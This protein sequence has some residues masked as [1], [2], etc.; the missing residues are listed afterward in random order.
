MI[1]PSRLR[2]PVDSL[3]VS[4]C[5][6]QSRCSPDVQDGGAGDGGGAICLVL[7]RGKV[8]AAVRKDQQ[9]K[10]SLQPKSTTNAAAT[11]SATEGGSPGGLDKVN[12]GGPGEPESQ[13]FLSGK[14]EGSVMLGGERRKENQETKDD[15]S[16]A[17]RDEPK[18]GAG[19][20]APHGGGYTCPSGGSALQPP[21]PTTQQAVRAGDAAAT[22]TAIGVV[23]TADDGGRIKT[24]N[25]IAFLTGVPSQH[26]VTSEGL[27]L[28][29]PETPIH[30]SSTIANLQDRRKS[31][32]HCDAR[33]QSSSSERGFSECDTDAVAR[34]GRG[35]AGGGGGTRNEER[36]STI[37][38]EEMS[39]SLC[40]MSYAPSVGNPSADGSI[41]LLQ[42][43]EQAVDLSAAGAQSWPGGSECSGGYWA[44]A[45]ASSNG[46]DRPSWRVAC[47]PNSSVEDDGMRYRS[48]SDFFIEG[49]T[50]SGGGEKER[51]GGAV[52]GEG[53][54]E[55]AARGNTACNRSTSNGLFSSLRNFV[56]CHVDPYKVIN[57][58]RHPLLGWGIFRAFMSGDMHCGVD[59]EGENR[60]NLLRVGLEGGRC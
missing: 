5:F 17:A 45:S 44:G 29:T 55:T 42:Q 40:D 59:W 49:V 28:N 2:P 35:A 47:S 26:V 12:F 18:A 23:Q 32:L 7:P 48:S 30:I 53:A 31:S 50:V 36:N 27:E 6:H 16:A 57:I 3:Y 10:R 13:H 56:A 8:E 33:L 51:F 38:A 46:G 20:A 1:F 60:V 21:L 52:W 58:L 25:K 11:E 14:E 43:R 41:G 39:Q 9:V 4:D 22:A 54:M 37:S 24:K 15:R 19:P 34:S